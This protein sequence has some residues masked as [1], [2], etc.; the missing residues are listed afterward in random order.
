[1]EIVAPILRGP[2]SYARC[3]LNNACS[4]IAIFD[5]S[6]FGGNILCSAVLPIKHAT[7]TSLEIFCTAMWFNCQSG[8]VLL[9]NYNDYPAE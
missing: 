3:A 4:K 5:N 6:V 8:L 9:T 2:C 1:M 7:Y